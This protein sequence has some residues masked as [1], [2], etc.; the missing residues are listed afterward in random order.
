MGVDP[1]HTGDNTGQEGGGCHTFS[2][3]RLVWGRQLGNAAKEGSQV[4]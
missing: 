3:F 1:N 4:I 2:C